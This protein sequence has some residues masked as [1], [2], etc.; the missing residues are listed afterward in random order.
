M[1]RCV[2][3]LC[4]YGKKKIA[5]TAYWYKKLK[6][7][8]EQEIVGEHVVH[9]LMTSLA[10]CGFE[11]NIT[12]FI[13]NEELFG[14]MGLEK[15]RD[16]MITLMAFKPSFSANPFRLYQGM[17]EANDKLK[18]VAENLEFRKSCI[19]MDLSLIHI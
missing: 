2:N 7:R 1:V 17:K 13:L 16:Q 11:E 10:R 6:I 19:D 8:M 4:V 9:E 3:L 18:S 15:I 5:G 12:D 14:P